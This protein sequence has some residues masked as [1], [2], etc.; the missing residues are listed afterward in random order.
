MCLENDD[1]LVG[2]HQ[3]ELFPDLFLD[4]P[5]IRFES[6]D[7]VLQGIDH[8]QERPR[9]P[10][11][12]LFGGNV[13]DLIPGFDLVEIHRHA[14]AKAIG[15]DRFDPFDTAA[16][17]TCDGVGEWTTTSLG[18][19]RGN[20]IDLRCEQRFPHS[21]GLLYSAF[22]H[23]TGFRVNSGE[24][25]LMDLRV[26]VLQRK[27]VTV[28]FHNVQNV[29]DGQ[30]LR[31]GDGNAARAEAAASGPFAPYALSLTSSR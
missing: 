15:D 1:F 21:L 8:L 14:P 28:Q 2:S 25:K 17:L 22:T 13:F 30:L 18:E 16:I 23:F 26:S 4:G 6:P 29:V 7:L 10:S 31:E 11:G 5:G 3:P 9:R 27:E 12:R 24:Y 20:R 19:G